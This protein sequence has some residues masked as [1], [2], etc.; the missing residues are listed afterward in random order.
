MLEFSDLIPEGVSRGNVLR[1]FL[2][3]NPGGG[4]GG[5]H[6]QTVETEEFR[7]LGVQ[8]KYIG[9]QMQAPGMQEWRTRNRL[10]RGLCWNDWGL[11]HRAPN[12][13]YEEE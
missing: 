10:A 1:G 11:I 8:R 13:I 4:L 6:G 7:L 3:S 2:C 9:L 12:A 5:D